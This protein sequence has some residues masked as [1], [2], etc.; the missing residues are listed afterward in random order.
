MRPRY[1]VSSQSNTF[2]PVGTAM[3]MVVMPKKALTLALEPMVKKWCSQTVNDRMRDRRRGVDQRGVAEQ[4]LAARRSP[5]TSEIDAEGRQDQDV[6]LRMAPDPEQV[7]VVH[8]VAAGVI[9]EEMHAEQAVERQQR[10]TPR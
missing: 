1:I 9:G 7:G 3:I 5:T 10:R 6:D 2:T 8:H 4:P